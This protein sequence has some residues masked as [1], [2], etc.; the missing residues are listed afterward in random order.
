MF[1]RHKHEDLLKSETLPGMTG[2]NRAMANLGEYASAQRNR[3]LLGDL[4]LMAALG[5][6]VV[7][8]FIT[9]GG[10]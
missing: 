7:L 3:E 8:D 5:V 6:F 9:T 4:I 2:W 10:R 1:N